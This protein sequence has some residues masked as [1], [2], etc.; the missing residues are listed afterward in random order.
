MNNNLLYNKYVKNKSNMNKW[1]IN[2]N[3]CTE[4]I[5]KYL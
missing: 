1:I 3:E 4:D 5:Y 2:I